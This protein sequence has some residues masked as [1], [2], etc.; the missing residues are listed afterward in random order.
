MIFR[1]AGLPGPIR[2]AKH[3]AV[4]FAQEHL[5]RATGVVV[6]IVWAG[7]YR[8]SRHSTRPAACRRASTVEVAGSCNKD[9]SQDSMRSWRG[10]ASAARHNQPCSRM[11]RVQAWSH[12][13]IASAQLS[14][15]PPLPAGG[16]PGHHRRCPPAAIDDRVEQRH[17]GTLLLL[18]AEIAFLH[19][20]AHAFSRACSA[21]RYFRQH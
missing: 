11:P 3:N 15:K 14:G 8:P 13:A 4:A 20:E 17:V 9:R 7:S 18:L 6:G 10:P 5:C 1:F 12:A 16:N 2:A 21:Q 19:R